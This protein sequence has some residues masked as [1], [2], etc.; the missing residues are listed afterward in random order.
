MLAESGSISIEFLVA[1][2]LAD[3]SAQI[4]HDLRIGM[5]HLE[6][7]AM[8]ILPSV[9]FETRCFD[10][11]TFVRLGHAECR[12]PTGEAQKTAFHRSRRANNAGFL[13]TIAAARPSS[14]VLDIDACVT[15]AYRMTSVVKRTRACGPAFGQADMPRP[16]RALRR[17]GQ[18]VAARRQVRA[19]DQ[20]ALE[21]ARL[22][23]AVCVGDFIERD[24]LRDAWPD[25]VACQ[26][27]EQLLEVFSEPRRMACPHRIDRV[28]ADGLAA[29]QPA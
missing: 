18:P 19:Q 17:G 14:V 13:P 9:Q 11:V 24:P 20:L 16:M 21:T 26:H 4:S 28:K 25:G 1:L 6:C 3:R 27:A 29:R 2:E 15:R 7:F 8:A 12:R 23:A 22:E 5:H 10:H